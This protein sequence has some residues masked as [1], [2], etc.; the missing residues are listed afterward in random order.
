VSEDDALRLTDPPPM[1]YS[2]SNVGELLLGCLEA[3]EPRSILEIGSY[4]GDL[5]VEVLD[6]AK[7]N[8]AEVA[9][10]DPDPPP[11]LRERS[12][13]HPELV[14][15]EATSHE[16][17]AGLD[18]APDA[19]IIDGDHNYFTLSEELRLIAELVGE[20]PLPLLMFHDVCWPHARRDTYYDADRIPEDKRPPAGKDV[21]LAP[22]NAGVDP[23]GLPYPWA[24]LREGGPRNGTLTAIEDFMGSREDLRLAIVPAFFGFGVLWPDQIQGAEQLAELLSPFDRHPVLERL[25]RNRVE[26]LV[27]GFA[28][29][30]R[31]AELEDRVRRQE[32]LLR[33]MLDSRAFTLAEYV[34][35]AY[36]R[37]KPTFS[38]EKLRRVL[39]R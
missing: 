3:V 19:V 12:S 30:V 2:L 31:I 37:G 22:G 36:Q 28:R 17:L 34:S 35:R 13:A 21:G 18:A 16:V 23:S 4:E 20:D 26:H 38:R 8:G 24:A 11:K 32:Y 29:G 10:V 39:E 33:Q 6:W 5:T 9:T 7:E 1:G 27:A 15:H 25:E 14:L